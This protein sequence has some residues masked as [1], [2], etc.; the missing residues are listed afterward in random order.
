VNEKDLKNKQ[1]I[2]NIKNIKKT[3][4]NKTKC[5]I[6]ENVS[7]FGKLSFVI[8]KIIKIWEHPDADTLFCEEIDLGE[9]KVRT[10]ASG[11]RPFIS[12]EEM[13]NRKVVVFSNLKAR[14]M[15]GFWSHGMV[16]CASSSDRKLCCPIVPPEDSKIG[17]RIIAKDDTGPSDKELTKNFFEKN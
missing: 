3:D 12:K 5:N 4:K 2:N 8:G 6:N 9:E 17:D 16:M 11:L 10:I 14:N 13:V 7:V 15:K 1:K